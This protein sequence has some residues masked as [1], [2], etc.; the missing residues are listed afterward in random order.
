MKNVC[1]LLLNLI[2]V[3]CSTSNIKLNSKVVLERSTGDESLPE[4]T[5][6][7][8]NSWSDENNYYFKTS[9]IIKGSQRVNACYDFAKSEAKENI[10]NEFKSSFSSETNG[11]TEGLE[12]TDT[13][14]LN[15]MFISSIKTTLYGLK[16]SESAF[17]RYKI[18]DDEKIQCHTLH[19]VTKDN[20][21]KNLKLALSNQKEIDPELNEKILG[22]ARSFFLEN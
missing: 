20:F 13:Q 14:K 16:L 5:M 8:R 12:E 6:K 22:R 1:F 9:Y 4:W 18:L 3:G 15:K 17:E 19:V 11:Y 21:I 2:I 10:T 7:S